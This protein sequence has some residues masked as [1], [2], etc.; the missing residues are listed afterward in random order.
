VATGGWS[1]P[2]G[3]FA[4]F[5]ENL[6]GPAGVNSDD[7]AP[8][9]LVGPEKINDYYALLCDFYM[10]LP[11]QQPDQVDQKGREGN[12]FEVCRGWGQKHCIY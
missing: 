5:C 11:E 10:G 7:L 12:T 3:V 2:G 8:G 9:D 4:L 6:Q 1:G